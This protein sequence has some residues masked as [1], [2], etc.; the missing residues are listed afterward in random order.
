M[1]T[2]QQIWAKKAYVNVKK[3]E[4]K[5]KDEKE[6]YS[7]FCKSFPA[8]LH[9]Y[10]LCQ[11]LAFAEAKS[12]EHKEYLDHLKDILEM[13]DLLENSR[14]FDVIKYQRI[15]KDTMVAATW[16]KRYAEAFLDKEVC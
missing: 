3:M 6:K 5:N 12:K 4:R 8:L 16:L 9:S 15:S 1:L 13:I 2:R 7:S 11:A 10:G 14:N